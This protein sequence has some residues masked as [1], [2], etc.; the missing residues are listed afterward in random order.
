MKEKKL[1]V[2]TLVVLALSVLGFP[3][4]FGQEM[5]PGAPSVVRVISSKP[6]VLWNAECHVLA[7]TCGALPE[8]VA[9]L[10][11]FRPQNPKGTIVF[12]TGGVGNQ[13]YS[14]G[15]PVTDQ[16]VESVVE[17]GYEAIEVA[18]EGEGGWATGVSGA[19]FRSAMC[20]PAEV[21]RWISS[22]KASESK[23]LC[24]EGGSG[25]AFQIAYGLSVYGLEE[26][27]DMVV[28]TAGPPVSRL[29]VACLGTDDPQLKPSV[30]PDSIARTWAGALV[31]GVMGWSQNGDYC[32]KGTASE[33]ALKQLRADSLVS[34]TEERDYAYPRTKVNF[35]NSQADGTHAN[36]QA[37]LYFEKVTSAKAWYVIP[38]DSHFVHG[39]LEGAKKI[40]ELHLNECKP[41]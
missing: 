39:T 32:K 36:H 6:C 21:V 9:K 14:G 27:L 25:G 19:G 15:S 16:T 33:Q 5:A 7:V 22:H 18:W 17:A 1:L 24:A 34:P 11:R 10:R 12:L 28:L 23:A 29:D 20:A 31:D 37:R 35:V 13:A 26:V 38:G 3:F 4:V 30:W 41:Q 40:R 2:H 8:R